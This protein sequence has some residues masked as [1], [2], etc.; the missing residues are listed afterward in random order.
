MEQFRDVSQSDVQPTTPEDKAVN[1]ASPTLTEQDH[2]LKTNGNDDY[3]VTS[4]QKE[5]WVLLPSAGPAHRRTRLFLLTASDEESVKKQSQDLSQY[6]QT[7]I[8]EQE[9]FLADLAFTLANRRSMLDWRLA[10]SVS[11]IEELQAAFENSDFH[12]N[13]VSKTPGL[14]FVFTG[15]GAQWPTMGQQLMVYP[16]FASALR[17]ADECLRRLGAEWSLLGNS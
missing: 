14:G 7:K 15:Q 8:N 1:G 12:L 11:S 4:L 3:D 9:S 16:V 17:E 13:R 5:P 2:A 6:L 10:A